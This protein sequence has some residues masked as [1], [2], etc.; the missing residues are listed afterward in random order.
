[1][2]TYHTRA[3]PL[4]EA[5][6]NVVELYIFENMSVDMQYVHMCL[7]GYSVHI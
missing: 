3:P 1:M 7:Y 4:T 2:I 5:F 6:S